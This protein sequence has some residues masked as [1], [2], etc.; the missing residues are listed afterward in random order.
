MIHSHL[1]A[2]LCASGFYS[3]CND[4]NEIADC[5]KKSCGDKKKSNSSDSGCQKEHLA[6]F[7]TIGQ[8][9]FVKAIE[10]KFFQPFVLTVSVGKNIQPEISAEVLFAFNRFHPPTAKKN[11]IIFQ[12][13]FL[14]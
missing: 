5:C 12:Q 4:G 1:C 9:H 14:I 2:G 6:M 3:C 10:E 11:M 8:F 7:S 13:C